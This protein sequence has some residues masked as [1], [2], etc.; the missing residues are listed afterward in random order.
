MR[1]TAAPGPCGGCSRWGSADV[2]DAAD[3]HAGAG[4]G[5]QGN[6]R[7]RARRAR[8]RAARGAELDVQ[9]NEVEL[10]AALGDVLRAIRSPQ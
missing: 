4:E 9:G 8:L 5:T 6:L 3:L 1:Q 7:A 10:L 2:L